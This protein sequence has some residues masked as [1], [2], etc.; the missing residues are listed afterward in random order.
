MPKAPPP[1]PLLLVNNLATTIG[2]TT[3]ELINAVMHCREENYSWDEIAG[4]L[5]VSRQAA[6]RRFR[7]YEEVSS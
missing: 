3:A 5:G 6:H 1:D 2:S 4:A 7:G